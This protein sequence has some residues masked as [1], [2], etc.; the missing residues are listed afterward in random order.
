MFISME[1][2]LERTRSVLASLGNPEHS[3]CVLHVAGTNGK[4]SVVAMLESA[5]LAGGAS[6]CAFVSPFL[7]EPR[8]SF[9][10]GGKAVSAELWDGALEEVRAAKVGETM[11]EGWTAAALLLASRFAV[12]VFVL[13]VGL[14]G[15]RDATNVIP[16]PLAAI[17]TSLSLD[18]CD[19]IGPTIRE[20]SREK[21]GIF[22]KNCGLFVSVPGQCDIALG[23]LQAAAAAVGGELLVAELVVPHFPPQF[24]LAGDFQRRN[25]AA[26]LAVL[27]FIA[28][29]APGY[30]P[31]APVP[32][33]LTAAAQRVL[34]HD[35]AILT[36][37]WTGL[38]VAGRLARVHLDLPS[39]PL[40]AIIDGG[41]NVEAMA[42]LGR[43]LRVCASA[44]P[45]RRAVLVFACGASRDVEENLRILFANLFEPEGGGAEGGGGGGGAP[46]TTLALA[47]VHIIGVAF[48]P[49][50]GMPWVSPHTSEAIVEAAERATKSLSL[51][52]TAAVS[53]ATAPSL[54]VALSLAAA[55]AAA[56][57]ALVAVC[58]SLYLVSDIYREY[59]PDL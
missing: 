38:R 24:G 3:I 16:P 51:S 6:V 21:S 53:L 50:E 54:A 57:S 19:L 15:A 8:D 4:G 26:A 45:S 25:A 40:A 47:A 23:V 39:G 22:K 41:H 48:S 28:S 27:R 5:L 49:P 9:R 42:A 44:I 52:T 46:P 36:T 13:E 14:G 56:D 55:A 30:A 34:A 1:L 11:F 20:I 29:G 35:G 18:H 17:I 7:R 31:A 33:G 58:G 37:A 12:D 10:V 59:L 32:T 2:G 43:E